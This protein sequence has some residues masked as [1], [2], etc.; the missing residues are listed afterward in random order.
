MSSPFPKHFLDTWTDH[1]VDNDEGKGK[2]QR[3]RENCS[4]R[5]VNMTIEIDKDLLIELL[6]SI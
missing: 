1:L 2:R 3:E 4:I 5:S 6:L